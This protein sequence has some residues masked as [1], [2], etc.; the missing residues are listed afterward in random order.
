MFSAAM[1]ELN[2][3]FTTLSNKLFKQVVC[4]MLEASDGVVR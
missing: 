1:D 2:N 3:A 4:V